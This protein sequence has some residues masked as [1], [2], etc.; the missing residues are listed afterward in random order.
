MISCDKASEICNKSQYKEAGFWDIW[1]LRFHI[2]FCK[3][4]SSH[5]K[6]NTYLTGLCEK[7]N[8]HTLSAKENEA[9]KQRIKEQ[10]NS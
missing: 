2:L 8:L 5:T 6:K 7:A 1:K 4:C 3:H 9:I 10:A